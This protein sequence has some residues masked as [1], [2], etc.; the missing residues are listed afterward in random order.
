MSL[1]LSFLL[2]LGLSAAST[3]F[4]ERQQHGDDVHMQGHC[5]TP[6]EARALMGRFAATHSTRAEWE[7]RRDK[8][9]EGILRGAKLWPLPNDRLPPKVIRHSQR[10]LNGYSVE[11]VAIETVEGFW[12]CG[13]LYLPVEFDKRS[14]KSIPGVLCPHGHWQDGRWAPHTQARSAAMARMGCAVFAYD[15]VGH[16][17]TK[18]LEHKHPQSLR[19]QTWDSIRA[20]DFL[21]SLQFVDQ[22]RLAVTGCSGGGTQTFLLAALDSRV[23]LAM[24]VCQVSAHFYGGC[25]CESGMPIHVAPNHQTNNAEIAALFAPRPMLLVSNGDDW[26]SDTPTTE[27]PYIQRVYEYYGAH[28]RLKNAHYPD[29]GHDYG[30]SK[31][32]AAYRF[33]A[34]QFS[35]D[36]SQV[37]NDANQLDESWLVVQDPQSLRVFSAARPR[38]GNAIDSSD[39]LFARLDRIIAPA[40]A[41]HSGL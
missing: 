28:S 37:T 13:N 3:L 36:L 14:S 6:E 25:V 8:I 11:N 18:Q 27:L 1:R 22:A 2:M 30:P 10:V 5:H 24:P 32:E 17:E 19:L 21:S 31:R 20:L 12:L 33:I 7:T 15:M 26:T 40:N 38:P 23:D 41:P 34:E 35:L 29:E 4:A 39:V 16:A 9:R